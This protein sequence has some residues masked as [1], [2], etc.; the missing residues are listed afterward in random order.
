MRKFFYQK[1]TFAFIAVLLFSISCVKQEVQTQIPKYVF[2][3]IGDGMGFAHITA[4]ESYLASQTDLSAENPTLSFTGFPVMGMIT[5]HSANSYITCSSAAGTALSTG[6]KTNNGML[7]IDPE[8]NVIKSI[9]YDLK[10]AGY[11]IG[12]ATSVSI[13]HATPAAFF[14]NDTIRN[15]YYN[16]ARQLASSGFDFFAGSGFLNPE[17]E[18]AGGENVYILI[19][20]ADYAVIRAPS[21]LIQTP[22]SKKIVMVQEE[23]RERSALIRAIDRSGNDGWTL[24]DFTRIGI[25]RLN[26]P[27]GFF[28]MVE[29]GQIDW[30]S[31]ANDA[32]AMIYEMIDFSQAVQ[33]A[34]EFYRKHPAET[35]IIV[36]A[37][38][39]TGGLSLGSYDTPSE[40]NPQLIRA[41]KGGEFSVQEVKELTKKTG[42]GW[43]T[44][45]HTG[46]AVPLFA[47]G[48][49]S[50]TFGG[51]TDNT[52]VAKKI[53]KLMK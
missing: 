7:G 21:Q 46:V 1:I 8:G 3:F 52:D 28:F 30:T 31:H 36:T 18:S 15:N 49:G 35:L 10:A 53:K 26:N 9:T 12:I 25:E 14:A 22:L 16:I 5:T 19:E 50:K 13:D 2:L 27:K 17:D 20:R 42:F 6:V 45:D 23:K 39:E 47:I 43:S 4:A 40:L 11:K 32:A 34:L 41:L 37:D 51:K 29:G 38:H 44:D 33:T 48:A 24:T